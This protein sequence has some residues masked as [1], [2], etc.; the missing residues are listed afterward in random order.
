M[1][2]SY[3]CA[4]AVL[5]SFSMVACLAQSI[6]QTSS[7][8]RILQTVDGGRLAVISG[9]VRSQ[10]ASGV[11]QGRVI[12]DAKLNGVSMIFKPS[13]AQQQALQWLLAQQ[14]NPASSNYH[15]W[16]TPDQYAARFGMSE[17]DLAKVTSWLKSQGL[18]V[19]GM[20]RGR[21][22][23]SFA[24]T[25]AQV[26]AAL[27]TEI[28]QYL[29]NGETHFA[30]AFDPSVPAA[31]SSVILGFRGLDNFQPKSH[32]RMRKLRGEEPQ[33]LFT[34]SISGNHFVVPDDFATIYD[35]KALYAAG[36]DGTGETIAVTG[37]STISNTDIDAFRTAANLTANDPQMVLVPSTG[38]ASECSGDE[39]ES[40][41]DVEWSGAVA[42]N[43][44]V[45]FVFAGLAT[46]DTCANRQF[47]AFD[48]L[49]Y[50]VDQD[51]APVISNSY[52]LCESEETLAGAQIIQQIA[53]Q[54]NTQGQTIVSATGDAG[55]A[56]CDTGSSGTLGLAVDIPAAIPEVTGAGGSEFLADVNNPATYWSSTNNANQGSA[57]EYIPEE[58]WNDTAES[59]AGGQGLAAGGGGASMFF[60]KPTWQTG[61][62][63][64]A[65]N[66]RYVPDI[67]LNASPFHDPYL[68]CSQ[69]LLNVEGV[70]ATSCAGSSPFRASDNQT[71]DAVGGTSAA[72]PSF[73]GILAIINQATKTSQGNINPELYSLATSQPAAF[74]DIITGN[75]IVP[76]TPGTL[77][78]PASAPFQY[79][80]SAGVGYD[81]VTGLGSVNGDILVTN[82]PGYSTTKLT[83]AITVQSSA[84]SIVLGSTAVITASGPASGPFITG[85]VQFTVDGGNAGTA[86]ALAA[87]TAMFTATNLTAGVH[88][89]AAAYSGDV[90][91]TT[92]TSSELTETV[93]SFSV[94]GAAVSIGAPG[95]SGTS[96]VTIASSNGL[97]GAVALS[98]APML[99]TVEITCTMTPA[100]VTLSSTTTSATAT[101]T[102]VTTAPH[103]VSVKSAAAKRP[104]GF[105]W[106]MVSGGA[107][108]AG[109]FLLAAPTRRRRWSSV[110]GL[111]LFAFL[112]AGIGCGGGGTTTPSDPGT[113]AGSYSVVVTGTSGGGTPVTATVM[114]TVQ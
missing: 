43:A 7:Q 13:P 101:A 34:S 4:L 20:S 10:M 105:G 94:T 59:V 42:K 83:P 66:F 12:G 109:V 5:C 111:V 112:A 39:T 31:F 58:A 9:N 48:A 96:T 53:Q 21:N 85:T 87:G 56:D 47:G 32:V 65:G 11:D 88:H 100:S 64:P 69:D 55:A 61:T 29:V 110:L 2:F 36:F 3:K 49:Q 14:Q 60:T 71:L 54:A 74:H 103:V 73:A 57:L 35:L 75:N 18:T 24:G 22:Q 1:N 23:I 114:V 6:P 72:A 107:S 93:T 45:I 89:I 16:L 106:F 62:G 81:E 33:P 97:S 44:S 38:T 76:C 25:V 98:C 78:C 86:V 19:L 67:A 113:P 70:A 92:A 52:G 95:S 37:Q 8:N 80:N 99:T 108:L 28:H 63:V 84:V 82:W 15:R 104:N 46:G 26:E 90:N 41:L 91:Y 51:V 27:H 77:N 79:G 102:V 17:A 30:N 68:I 50:A 40:D